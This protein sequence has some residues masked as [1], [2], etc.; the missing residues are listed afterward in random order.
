MEEHRVAGSRLDLVPVGACCFRG[1][2]PP[3]GGVVVARRGAVVLPLLPRV[4][5]D[6]VLEKAGVPALDSRRRRGVGDGAAGEKQA[7][8]LCTPN[9]SKPIQSAR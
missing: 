3:P 7:P 4:S 2:A 6:V 5:R 8:F 9:G 1:R